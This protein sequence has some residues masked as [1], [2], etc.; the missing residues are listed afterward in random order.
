M[1]GAQGNNDAW[2]RIS[3]ETSEAE[4]VDK[5]LAEAKINLG[6]K[7]GLTKDGKPSP[8]AATASGKSRRWIVFTPHTIVSWDNTKLPD[9]G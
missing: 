9:A 1:A 3:L 7:H 4:E 2:Q 6:V 8:Y 5:H